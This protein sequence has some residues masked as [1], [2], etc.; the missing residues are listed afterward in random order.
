MS[1]PVLIDYPIHIGE[2]KI[3]IP[4]NSYAN[5]LGGCSTMLVSHVAFVVTVTLFAIISDK[6]L[7]LGVPR[8]WKKLPHAYSRTPRILPEFP[9]NLSTNDFVLR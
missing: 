1:G 6:R 5:P 3:R 9:R 7:L 4:S 2:T 8:S